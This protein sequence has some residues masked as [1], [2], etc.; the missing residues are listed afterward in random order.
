MV[1]VTEVSL[2]TVFVVVALR[3]GICRAE[4]HRTSKTLRVPNP[5]CS[6][7]WKQGNARDAATWKSV[8][9]EAA[10]VVGMGGKRVFPFR[11]QDVL[12]DVY[13]QGRGLSVC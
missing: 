6:L 7:C 10:W 8:L 3:S 12:G 2:A 11:T 5:I 13:M 9:V 1:V 4:E